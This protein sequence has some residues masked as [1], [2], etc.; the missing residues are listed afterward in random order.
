MQNMTNVL[1]YGVRGVKGG[2]GVGGGYMQEGWGGGVIRVVRI[3]TYIWD[4]NCS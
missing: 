3:V 1:G 2:G 4:N